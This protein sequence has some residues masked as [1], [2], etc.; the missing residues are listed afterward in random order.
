MRSRY[1]GSTS[2]IRASPG[3]CSRDPPALVH[4]GLPLTREVSVEEVG[5]QGA[6]IQICVELTE[7]LQGQPGDIKDGF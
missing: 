2:V 3:S 5:R 4:G 6:D 7:V 1:P